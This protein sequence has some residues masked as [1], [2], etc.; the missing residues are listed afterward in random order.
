MPSLPTWP[1]PTASATATA[2]PGQPHADADTNAKGERDTHLHADAKHAQPRL[3]RRPAPLSPRPPNDS[4]QQRNYHLVTPF[5]DVVNTT[6][7]TI[8]ATDPYPSCGNGSRARNVWYRFTAPSNGRITANTFGSNYNTILSA[9]TG[10]CGTL[11]PVPGAC[12]VNPGVFIFP[13]QISF[14]A[15]A[16]H[17]LLLHGE[18]IH[19]TGGH[20]LVPFH[21]PTIHTGSDANPDA[22]RSR[23]RHTDADSAEHRDAYANR[24]KNPDGNTHASSGN[25]HPLKRVA[26]DS[27]STATTV[28]SLPYSTTT[29]VTAA[30]ISSSD[31][32]PRCGNASRA[33]SVWYRYTAPVSRTVTVDTFGSD[34]DTILSLYTGWCG[35]PQPLLGVCNDNANGTLQS[36]ITFIAWART[37]Y[38]FMVTSSTGL[39]TT[40]VFNMR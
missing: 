35:A 16:G 23:H 34:Y 20:A 21:V 11:T 27:C 24:H 40:S 14:N 30:T 26:N 9:F 22:L 37:T 31:P 25:A 4:L 12:T 3:V 15:T 19:G 36:Q 5:A 38:Y 33:K 18:L 7:G 8:D 28:L 29:S 6:A 10:A 32:V 17:H 39:G 2:P 1:T 13:S